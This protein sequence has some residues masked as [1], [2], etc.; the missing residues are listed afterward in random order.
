M[1]V[2]TDYLWFNTKKRQEF[3]ADL[4]SLGIHVTINPH[5]VEFRS[6]GTG[7]TR[8]TTRRT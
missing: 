7:N 8:S 3:M 6:L 1:K 4:E 2:H 5:P